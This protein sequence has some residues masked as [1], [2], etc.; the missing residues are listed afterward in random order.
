[1]SPTTSRVFIM[2]ISIVA[3]ASGCRTMAPA[4]RFAPPGT[5]PTR[6]RK[7]FPL[8]DAERQ[9]LTPDSIK[10]LSQFQVDQIYARLNSGPIPD[11]PF[12][13][14]LFFPRDR[15]S[16]EAVSNLSDATPGALGALAVVPAE[17][18][19]R[20]FWRGKVLFRSQA[21][22]RNRI[23]DLAILKPIIE[24][25][26]TI[27]KLKFDGQTTWLLFPA[28]L[29]CGASRFDPTK[30]IVIDYAETEKLEGY[31]EIPDKIAGPQGLNIFDE[32][33]IVRRGFYLGRSY[34]G[35][36]FALNFTLVDPAVS[37]SPAPAP[38]LQEDCNAL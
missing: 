5:D 12:R 21:L 9:A 20:L 1:M 31:R 13:G 10:A 22:V 19:A 15:R 33:R 7:D 34:F 38:N 2:M 37:S 18:L 16:S 23:E 28:K 25:S 32:I 27:P 36:R 29:S 3:I 26:D 17:R 11:G 35:K 30:S 4:I 24:D 14:D 8:S 6:L